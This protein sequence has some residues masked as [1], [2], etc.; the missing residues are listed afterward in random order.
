MAS[1]NLDGD[2]SDE[3]EHGQAAV[4]GFAVDPGVHSEGFLHRALRRGLLIGHGVYVTSLIF[5][6]LFARL[7]GKWHICVISLITLSLKRS[8]SA[9]IQPNRR[10]R[11]GCCS[12][13]LGSDFFGR[14][15]VVQLTQK[16]C[17]QSS[18]NP[19]LHKQIADPV[20]QWHGIG[21][22]QALFECFQLTRI[23][24]PSQGIDQGVFLRSLD[25]HLG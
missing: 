15:S 4:P 3:A 14:S 19:P 5:A 10:R 17:C 2:G 21:G 13:G 9:T 24:A 6:T 20:E 1:G 22:L 7:C 16:P 23:S 25:Q 11:P 8:A 18:G 12:G